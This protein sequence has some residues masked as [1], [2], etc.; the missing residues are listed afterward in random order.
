[1]TV[2]RR[3]RLGHAERHRP[4]REVE[5]AAMGRTDTRLNILSQFLLLCLIILCSARHEEA[6]DERQE[7]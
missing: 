5:P 3:G 2:G 6:T 4:R 7:T 1:M